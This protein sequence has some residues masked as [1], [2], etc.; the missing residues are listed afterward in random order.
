MSLP[1]DPRTA[2]AVTRAFFH[3]LERSPLSTQEVATR[4]GVHVNSLYG[5]KNGKTAASVLNL[6]SVLAVLG[7]ELLIRP[8]N[9]NPEMPYVDPAE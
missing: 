2:S 7:F 3:A 9:T 4:G 8:L 1:G 6:E 5:W